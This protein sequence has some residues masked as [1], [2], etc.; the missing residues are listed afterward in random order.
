LYNKRSHGA[1]KLEQL[2][3]LQDA[4]WSDYQ[5]KQKSESKPG[6]LGCE[7]IEKAKKFQS[8]IISGKRCILFKSNFV[9]ICAF[10]S[11]LSHSNF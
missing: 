11:H 3:S 8:E 4:F 1:L 7:K 2:E 10:E 5:L 6:S 9:G